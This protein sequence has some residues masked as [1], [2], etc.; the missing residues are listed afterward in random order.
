M[1]CGH[2]AIGTYAVRVQGHAFV[3]F[4]WLPLYSVLF[5]KEP[6][7]EVGIVKQG[8]AVEERERKANEHHHYAIS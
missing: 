1:V 3:N 6:A 2:M 5:R 8:L 7:L 4:G